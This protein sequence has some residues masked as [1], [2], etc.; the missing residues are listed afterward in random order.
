M[1]TT[2]R[3]AQALL[4]LYQAC[5]D[6]ATRRRAVALVPELEELEELAETLT[7]AGSA[8]RRRLEAFSRGSGCKTSLGHKFVVCS[9]IDLD[10]HK[11]NFALSFDLAMGVFVT[12]EDA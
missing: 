10:E 3:E 9:D 11:R 8:R 4:M 7:F 12:A 2:F 5:P 6:E 1:I